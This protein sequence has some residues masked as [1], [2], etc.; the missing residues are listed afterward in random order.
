MGTN[1]PKPLSPAPG[2]PRQPCVQKAPPEHL[3]QPF[4]HTSATKLKIKIK[5][6]AT[7]TEQERQGPQHHLYYCKDRELLK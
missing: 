3:L 5:K 1:P 6:S 2:I 4:Y 7:Q